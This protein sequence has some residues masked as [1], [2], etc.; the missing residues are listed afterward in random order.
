MLFAELRISHV[1]FLDETVTVMRHKFLKDWGPE[2]DTIA[3]PPAAG[4]YS[5][6]TSDQI[7]EHFAHIIKAVILSIYCLVYPIYYRLR[8]SKVQ[9]TNAL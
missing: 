5:V 9:K 6:F 7:V 3:Y 1:D 4:K 2:R 8:N